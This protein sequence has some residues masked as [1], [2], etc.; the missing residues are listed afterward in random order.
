MLRNFLHRRNLIRVYS[1]IRPLVE[2]TF[3]PNP[4]VIINAKNPKYDKFDTPLTDFQ[5]HQI[6]QTKKLDL[7]IRNDHFSA[8]YNFWKSMELLPNTR[9]YNQHHCAKIFDYF[10]KS[11]KDDLLVLTLNQ[12]DLQNM[13]LVVFNTLL[14]H[15]CRYKWNVSKFYH[16]HTKRITP[17]IH[18]FCTILKFY[19]QEKSYRLIPSLEVEMK[20]FNVAKTIVWYST[21]FSYYSTNRMMEECNAV[22]LEVKQSGV[23]PDSFYYSSV[24]TFATKTKNVALGK[25]A[26]EGLKT[27]SDLSLNS[28][29]LVAMMNFSIFQKNHVEVDRLYAEYISKWPVNEV[30]SSVILKSYAMRGDYLKMESIFQKLK[31]NGLVTIQVMHI[32]Y[33]AYL[34]ESKYYKNEGALT[35]ALEILDFV[36][37]KY[38][39]QD[40]T[41][42]LTPLKKYYPEKAAELASTQN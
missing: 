20:K 22:M 27:K 24:L 37:R 15:Y 18:S 11:R 6:K 23:T 26:Y 9:E 1:E 25:S 33:Y 10:S 39:N 38:P 30:V 41:M 29:A 4:S 19:L 42:F 35:R 28:F 36:K 7:L 21:L 31:Q 3:E 17:T 8:V 14:G 5:R 2:P 13:D 34:M 16:D 12:I 40:L 32:V